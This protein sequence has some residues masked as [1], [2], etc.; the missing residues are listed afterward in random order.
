[1]GL[2]SFFAAVTL[3]RGRPRVMVRPAQEDLLVG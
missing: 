2:F 3:N 1:V